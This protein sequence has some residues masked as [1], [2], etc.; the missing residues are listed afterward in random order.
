MRIIHMLLL[1][2]L[3]ASG[4]WRAVAVVVPPAATNRVV[5]TWGSLGS[6]A[7]YYVQ[8]ST[9]LVTW[10]AATNTIGTNV[11]LTFTGNKSRTF[12]LWASNAPP[13]S[14]TLAWNPS[15][16]SNQVAGYFVYHGGATRSYTN[17]FDVGLATSAVVTNLAAGM[18]YYFAITAYMSSG[19]ESDYSNEAEWQCPLR[20]RIQRLP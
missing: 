19:L 10:T 3:S 8:T 14:A 17:R 13:Q 4:Q 16:S 18:A 15:V 2:A 6:G 9:N 20:L 11:N 1:A 5:L 7:R 12:R